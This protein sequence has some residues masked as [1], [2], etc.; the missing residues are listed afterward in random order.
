MDSER[1]K[2]DMHT[3]MWSGLTLT[4]LVVI[5]VFV[6]FKL[7]ECVKKWMEDKKGVSD[8]DSMTYT[9][10]YQSQSDYHSNGFG[11]HYLSGVSVPMNQDI[12]EP[13]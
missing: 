11:D 4:A 7:G 8:E 3:S 13:T 9:Y 10:V 2:K 1:R 12:G 6:L 5:V